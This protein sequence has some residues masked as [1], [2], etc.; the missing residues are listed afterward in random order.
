M[1]IQDLAG[2]NV[3]ILGYGKEGRAMVDAL[4]KYA[5]GCRITIADRD[6]VVRSKTYV[7]RSGEKYLNHLND[8][9]LII[10][11]P[12]IPPHLLTPYSLLL[13]T[14]T[15]IFL[16]T[17]ADTGAVVI[18]VTGSKGKSTTATLIHAIL[19]NAHKDIHLVGNI[20]IPAISHLKDAK[21]NTIFVQEMSSY[22]LMDL[23][24]SPHIAVVTSFFPEH[25]D[26]H[27]SL[28]AY[29]EAKKHIARFQKENDAIFFNAAF[30]E[31]KEIADES[32]G[33]KI[34]FSLKDSPVTSDEV[35][36]KGEH[37]LGNIAGAWSVAMHLG[38]PKEVALET[39]RKFEGLP[40]RLESIA[41]RDGI[42]WVNDSIATTP[43]T[44]V[45]ALNALGDR[46]RIII[47]GGQDRGYDFAPLAQKIADS[48]SLRMVI[49][50]PDSG[51]VIGKAIEHAGASVILS[52]ATTLEKAIDTAREAA[53]DP[54]PEPG[55]TPIVLLS[56][57][58]PSYGHFK[59]FEDRGEQFRS[60]VGR[61]RLNN[62]P[63]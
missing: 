1:R 57:A 23:T 50:L 60:L 10:K 5:A 14:P 13:T 56:P 46:V 34:P 45:A 37:N 61:G 19:K 9:D 54:K 12:G 15:Q 62:A 30:P 41:I 24:V 58:A 28:E 38:I 2:K 47:L 25:M 39:I 29:L 36:L 11:S 49:L 43:E 32:K 59:N 17:I 16:D 52:E 21:M 51:T 22:Q 40:H 18:G 6:E 33:K 44:A 35:L 27:G 53:L 8:F 7:V 26:Y 63:N 42:E 48:P 31:A 3:C 4:E 55:V 20:G